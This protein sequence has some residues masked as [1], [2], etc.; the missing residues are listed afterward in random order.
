MVLLCA[1]CGVA[2][3]SQA[4]GPSRTD[5]A[6][7]QIVR[8]ADEPQRRG[9]LVQP[10]RRVF[11]SEEEG[12]ELFGRVG[13]A[14][15]H[16]NGSL[17]I[18]ESQSQEIRVFDPGSGAH[19]FTIGGRGDGPGEFRRSGLLGFDGEGSAY[20]FDREHRRL[21]VYSGIGEFLRSHLLP[22][23]LGISPL[24]LHVTRA[25]TLLGQIPQ[26]MERPPADGSILRDTVRIW[27]MP[28]DGTSPTLVSQTLGALWYFRD[29]RQVS[30]PFASGSRPGFRDD[31]VYVIDGAG[32]ASYSVYGP[33]GLERRVEIDRPPRRVDDRSVTM[34]LEARRRGPFPEALL[35]IYED[36]L[37]DMPIPEARRNWDGLVSTDEG[38]VWL[39]RAGD[40]VEAVAGA[41]AA[42]Q[43]WDVFD[44]EG[45]FTGPVRLPAN[46]LPVQ[47]MGQFVLTLIFD[48]M[49]RAAVAI[50]DLRW[51]G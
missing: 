6:G 35:R 1:G 26:G 19:L 21:S 17:W 8:N 9:E 45:V 23:T 7:V 38:D 16:P 44:A 39:L 15:L 11:G 2:D 31:R 30:I 14:R 46:V 4:T 40:A 47:V 13:T 22:A 49:D 42:D 34:F 33:A 29:G 51:I 43:A 28:V 5:S 20:V 24:P 18:A 10:A 48:E 50:H 27:T 3:R 12:P 41:P 37:S 32:E 25:G 36:H